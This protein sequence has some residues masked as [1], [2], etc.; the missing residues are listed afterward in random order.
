VKA[1]DG[2]RANAVYQR[3]K[4]T[5]D[6]LSAGKELGDICMALDEARKVKVEENS[7]KI[8]SFVFGKEITVKFTKLAG[9]AR[10]DH[11]FAK[12]YWGFDADIDA[13]VTVDGEKT[14]ITGLSHKVLI[15][16]VLNKKTELSVPITVAAAAAQDIMYI[17][18]CTI[19][20]VVPAAVAA[21]MGKMG[22]KDAGKVAEKGAKYTASIPGAK[23]TAREVARLAARI[24]EDLE[25]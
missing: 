17:G 12:T 3:A 21:A 14:V 8:L 19:N 15:D 25:G 2:I 13:E 10:R 11:P 1:T 4:Y 24:M 22:W 18:C 20:V 23:N 6:E 7:G 5:Y 9:G 16:A